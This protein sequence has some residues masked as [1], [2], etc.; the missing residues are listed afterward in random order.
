MIYNGFAPTCNASH[1]FLTN[2]VNAALS[3]TIITVWPLDV[4]VNLT[5]R[6]SVFSF[7]I[8]NSQGEETAQCGIYTYFPPQS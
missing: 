5:V 7:C 1:V 3:D 8:M 6:G 4:S 2:T